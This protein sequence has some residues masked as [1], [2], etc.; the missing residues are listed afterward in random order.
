MRLRRWRNQGSL[1]ASS[2][3]TALFLLLQAAPTAAQSD[4]S[5]T[6]YYVPE[7]D[8][9]RPDGYSASATDAGR[10]CERIDYDPVVTEW[11]E[12]RRVP[13]QSFSLGER[14]REAVELAEPLRG[15]VH[16]YT[17]AHRRLPEADHRAAVFV[18]DFGSAVI[19]PVSLTRGRPNAQARWDDSLDKHRRWIV[20][21]E[22]HWL[23]WFNQ[24]T[25]TLEVDGRSW[26]FSMR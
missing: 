11:E 1:W 9:C 12:D 4:I 13:R 2:A 22:A 6:V 25:W 21:H 23:H 17:N 18:F 3:A 8:A 15:I 16:Q 5:V 19:A 26:S 10:V 14:A 7:R 24:I 20:H